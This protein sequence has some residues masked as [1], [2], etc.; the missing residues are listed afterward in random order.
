MFW[1]CGLKSQ[2]LPPPKGPSPLSTLPLPFSENDG[3][4][5]RI[6][7][8]MIQDVS[9]LDPYPHH[10]FKDPFPN[11]LTST[12]SQ[13][14]GMGM[15]FGATIQPLHASAPSSVEREYSPQR[16]LHRLRERLRDA[17]DVVS[18]IPNLERKRAAR[19]GPGWARRARAQEMGPSGRCSQPIL[20]RLPQTTAPW[21]S[22]ALAPP[23]CSSRS[24]T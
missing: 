14:L 15:S 23:P 5:G 7:H 22:G 17:F 13:G 8:L 3:G 2:S 10:L 24:W 11:K 4:I 1:A 20:H 9:S 6:A 16:L 12:G 18:V 19:T 21:A